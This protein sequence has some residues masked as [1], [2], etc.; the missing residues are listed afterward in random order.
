MLKHLFVFSFM[1][2]LSKE[3]LGLFPLSIVIMPQEQK[4]LHIYEPRYKQ[5]INDC[6]AQNKDFGIPAVVDGV[7]MSMG[8]RVKIVDIEKFYPDGKMDIRVE[9]V[10]I[11]KLNNLNQKL[12][13]K[14]YASG[15]IE[16][17]LFN[18]R[19]PKNTELLQLFKKYAEIQYNIKPIYEYDSS[20]S[21]FE[22]ANSLQLSNSEKFALINNT[23]NPII[24][25][26][27]LI[28]YLRLFIAVRVQEEQLNYNFMLN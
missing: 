14:L 23:Q 6:F 25:Q 9:G 27:I 4:Y 12:E 2:H 18:D 13:N 22:I 17:F 28:N 19:Y 15:E 24:Q 10:S 11:F 21:I 26:N 5:L 7:A 8:T 20:I 16:T 3:V 1:Q